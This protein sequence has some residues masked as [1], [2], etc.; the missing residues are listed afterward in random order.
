M[1]RGK[2]LA[3]SVSS[4]VA[5]AA[6]AVKGALSRGKTPQKAGTGAKKNAAARNGKAQGLTPKRVAC[7]AALCLGTA[8]A[9][10]LIAALGAGLV[11]FKGPSQSLGDLL[12][13]S[14]LETS[15]LK[16]VPRIYYSQAEVDAI[17]ARNEV[18]AVED[19][20]DT[21][22]IVIAGPTPEPGQAAAARRRRRSRK[23]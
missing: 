8:L 10:V 12:T 20:T 15:A 16:F 2:A 21:S 6:G 14:M 22:L 9:L 1:N 13:V 18:A 4:A 11:A 5:S 3:K 23:T 19:E 7:R 17:V